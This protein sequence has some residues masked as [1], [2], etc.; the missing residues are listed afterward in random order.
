[1]NSPLRYVYQIG[2]Q[3]IRQWRHD[4]RV[5]V[6]LFMLGA[7]SLIYIIP[8]YRNA[9]SIG[10][11]LCVW[12]A[13]SALMSNRFSLF[14]L[15]SMIVL[16]FS[17]FPSINNDSIHFFMS[18]TRKQWIVAQI[19]YVLVI[20]F[21]QSLIILLITILP[22][23]FNGSFNNEWSHPVKAMSLGGH[24]GITPENIR[25]FIPPIL[26]HST[27]PLQAVSI[28]YLG[29]YLLCLCCG[30]IMMYLRILR[31]NGGTIALLSLNALQWIV[32]GHSIE[33]IFYAV[34]SWISPFYHVKYSQHLYERNFNPYIPTIQQS[35]VVLLGVA[36]VF[37]CLSIINIKQFDFI[38]KGKDT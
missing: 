30:F 32:G 29:L 34:I 13:F 25:I 6:S 15:S 23:I 14:L 9:A 31:L 35:F 1:M 4:V 12:E 7:I 2:K 21:M 10:E 26:I 33:S 36:I 18:G 27:T 24:V 16:F 37:S 5:Y 19:S 28:Y 20:S 11:P 17:D 22:A 38:N 3:N 8:F